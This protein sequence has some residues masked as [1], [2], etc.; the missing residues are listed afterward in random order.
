M[1]GTVIIDAYQKSETM[2]LAE[3][4]EDLCSPN[5][6][7]GWASAGIYCFWDYYFEEILYI[8][9]AVNLSER[10]K[11]HNGILPLKKGSKQEKI[12]QYFSC[13]ERL[14]YTIFVQSPFSQPLVHRNRSQ[15]QK[16]AIQKNAPVQ[17][18]LSKEGRDNIHRVEGILIEAYRRRHGHFPPWN[19]IGGSIE[20]QNSVLPNNYNIVKS[21]SNP[22]DY[23][24]NPI[25]SR[26][27]IRELSNNADYVAFESYLH[28]VRM[29]MLI[30]GMEYQEA[31]QFTIEHDDYHTIDRLKEAKYFEKHLIV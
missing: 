14:G 19:E 24:R 10:F 16:F 15:Y 12:E 8:G 2:E 4:I 7:Y 1:F 20:G 3:A 26:S 31:L 22:D 17:D 30:F 9:L 5:D 29:Y 23:A 27:T 13:N 25:V 11:Q 18:L 21:F 6:S 28:T